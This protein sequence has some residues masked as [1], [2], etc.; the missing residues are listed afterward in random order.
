MGNIFKTTFPQTV[1]FY[2]VGVNLSFSPK[3]LGVICL[4]GALG[5]GLKIDSMSYGHPILSGGGKSL[6]NWRLQGLQ[7][8]NQQLLDRPQLKSNRRG[9]INAEKQIVYQG[10]PFAERPA[11]SV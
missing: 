4:A 10:C 11:G 2:D 6:F 9:Q 3:V 8:C 7:T 1:V 5:A